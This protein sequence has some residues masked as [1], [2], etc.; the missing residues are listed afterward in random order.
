MAA[1]SGLEEL[2]DNVHRTVDGVMRHFKNSH[3]RREK[4]KVI[5]EL[6]DEGRE[7]H[8]LVAYHRVRWLSLNVCV[9]RLA[10]LLP[11]IVSYFELEA[12]STS[13]RRSE[14]ANLQELYDELVDPKFQLYLYFLQGRLPILAGINIQLQTKGQD[15]FTSY[16][17]IAGFKKMFLEPILHEVEGGLHE[18]NIRKNVDN[19]DYDCTQFDDFKDKVISSGQLSYAQLH[20]VMKNIFKFHSCYRQ[21]TRFPFSRTGLCCPKRQLFERSKP[22]VL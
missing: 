4:L 20:E 15:L 17:K 3:V 10:D 9:Q 11:E 2:P 12:H 7:Y 18:S 19:I 1:K 22:Q 21:I 8:Q 13:I 6:S 16:Q 5:I 14:R